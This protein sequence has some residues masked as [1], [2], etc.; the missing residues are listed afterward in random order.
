LL[1]L[2]RVHP[3]ARG[4]HDADD[5]HHARSAARPPACGRRTADQRCEHAVADPRDQAAAMLR[6][7]RICAQRAGASVIAL[8]VRDP[9]ADRQRAPNCRKYLPITTGHERDRQEDRDQTAIVAAS[10]RT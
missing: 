2:A 4:D 8:E 9:D 10:A 5:Q 3:A 6:D 1:E 7:I